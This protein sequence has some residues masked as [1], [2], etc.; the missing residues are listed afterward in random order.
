MAAAGRRARAA[1]GTSTSLS[2][3]PRFALFTQFAKR[4]WDGVKVERL[5]HIAIDLFLLAAVGVVLGLV[6]PFGSAAIPSAP[7][8]FFWVGFTLA[9]YLVF[10]PVSAAAQWAAEETR[11]PHWLAIVLVSLV[12]SLPLAAAIGYALGGM[13]ITEYWFGA[14]FPILYAQV[15]AIGVGIHI[16]M[17]LVR[18]QALAPQ[19]GGEAPAPAA[20]A[21]GTELPLGANPRPGAAFLRRLPPALGDELRSLQIQDHYVEVHTALGSTLLLMRFRDAVAE[22][23]GAGLRVHR[24][25]WVAFAAMEALERDGRS[26]RLRLRGGGDVPVSRAELPAVRAALGNAAGP[27][28]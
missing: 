24:S 28:V 11:V 2:R 16:L 17:L 12:A 20:G 13:R 22:L 10:R 25:W 8:L 3:A 26:Y 5:R 19:P 27:G 21:T 6:A 9:G 15:A 18:R 7:R 4:E 1:S 14:R 23:E